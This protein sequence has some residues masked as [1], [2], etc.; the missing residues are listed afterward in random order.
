[1]TAHRTAGQ[2]RA[3]RELRALALTALD[4]ADVIAARGEESDDRARAYLNA[5]ARW[6]LGEETGAQLGARTRAVKT[7]RINVRG[8]HGD[9]GV[10]AFA[11]ALHYLD[12]ARDDMLRNPGHDHH[13]PRVC[14]HLIAALSLLTG[15]PLTAADARVW[16]WCNAHRRAVGEECARAQRDAAL[17]QAK[18]DKIEAERALGT[19]PGMETTR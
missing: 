17:R 7:W 16:S 10:A 5:L 9:D 18:A 4:V 14:R 1:M 11:M 6:T 3:L 19:L 13:A 15:D 8:F 12:D 2:L